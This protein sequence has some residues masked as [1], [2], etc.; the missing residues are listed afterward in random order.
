MFKLTLILAVLCLPFGIGTNRPSTGA[1]LC[2]ASCPQCAGP[3]VLD[4][5]HECISVHR[6]ALG[7]VY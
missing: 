5:G 6:C 3:C 2:G 7:H 1:D 4:A